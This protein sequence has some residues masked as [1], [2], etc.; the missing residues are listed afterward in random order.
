MVCAVRHSALPDDI[1]CGIAEGLIDP[2]THQPFV[3]APPASLFP[4]GSAGAAAAGAAAGA[5][6]TVAP[7]APWQNYAP[8]EPPMD[9]SLPGFRKKHSTAA[10][11]ASQMSISAM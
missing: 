4:V 7:P 6:D 1:A 5:N 11:H 8:N 3:V 10:H 2:D 9:G